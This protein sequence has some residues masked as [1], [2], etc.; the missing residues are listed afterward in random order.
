MFFPTNLGFI[1]SDRVWAI[2]D[3]QLRKLELSSPPGSGS[4][5]NVGLNT[6][7]STEPHRDELTSRRLMFEDNMNQ[8]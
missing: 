2:F 4:Y 1:F 3:S 6:R 7:I 8:L 5:V